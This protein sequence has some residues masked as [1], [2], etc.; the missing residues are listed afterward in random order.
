MLSSEETKSSHQVSDD[1]FRLHNPDCHDIQHPEKSWNNPNYLYY[2]LKPD[3]VLVTSWDINKTLFTL[4]D[5]WSQCSHVNL[6]TG[7][8]WVVTSG[9]RS[10]PGLEHHWLTASVSPPSGPG[11]GGDVSPQVLGRAPVVSRA[12]QGPVC[13]LGSN[14]QDTPDWRTDTSYCVSQCTY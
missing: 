3:L 6:V 14:C 4:L 9:L 12:G 11:W 2:I 1:I 13:V 5:V 8:H 7:C 10:G